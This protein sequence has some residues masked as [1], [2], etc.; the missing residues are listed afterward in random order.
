MQNSQEG[1]PILTRLELEKD[2]TTPVHI[3][4]TEPSNPSASKYCS[5]DPEISFWPFA[6]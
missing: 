3:H 4:R 6:A 2:E 5:L 1:D